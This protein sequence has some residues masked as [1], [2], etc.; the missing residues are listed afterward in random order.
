MP[1]ILFTSEEISSKSAKYAAEYKLRT[2]QRYVKDTGLPL[3]RHAVDIGANLGLTTVAIHN[4]FPG[5]AIHAY[6]AVEKYAEAAK[7]NV[8]DR[9]GVEVFTE[10]VTY[11]HLFEDD[12]GEVPS[13]GELVILE[14]KGPESRTSWVGG[15]T[16][17]RNRENLRYNTSS[18][19]LTHPNMHLI[20]LD[21]VIERVPAAEVDYMKFD[22]EGCEYSNLACVDENQLRRVRFISGEYHN[23]MRFYP[24]IQKVLMKTHRVWL[25]GHVHCG[26]FF[27]V[28]RDMEGLLTDKM[29][30]LQMRKGL[31]QG[32]KHRDFYTEPSTWNL[33]GDRYP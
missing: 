4:S 5:V 12:L 19:T 32:K 8:G 10:A 28:R 16:V 23:S 11:Q 1:R 31:R 2:I 24:S 20:T 18:Y 26:G 14:G 27:A 9:R 21:D 25:S 30:P 6:E 29:A 3:V 17:V 7:K 22:C 13:E 15:S 33:F